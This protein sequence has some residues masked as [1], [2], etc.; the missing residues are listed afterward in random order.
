MFLY[1]FERDARLPAGS[2]WVQNGME[3][4]WLEWLW[5]SVW[6]CY[7]RGR[8][9]KTCTSVSH[10]DSCPATLVGSGILAF[11]NPWDPQGFAGQTSLCPG[12]V[13]RSGLYSCGE[14][15]LHSCPGP[16]AHPE[17][18]CASWRTRKAGDTPTASSACGSPTYAWT[19]R[20]ERCLCSWKLS[21]PDIYCWK[22]LFK[23]W[24]ESSIDCVSDGFLFSFALM[25]HV[26][27]L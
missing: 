3:Q 5:E 1:K 13:D 14:G 27:P 6:V 21:L 18:F 8:L 7:D 22:S 24:K 26:F 16:L 2:N 25:L 17:F 20:R 23:E 12:P 4:V 10:R 19:E 11:G 9:E 15:L